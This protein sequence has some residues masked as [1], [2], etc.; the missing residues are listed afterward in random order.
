MAETEVDDEMAFEEAFQA[1]VV[2]FHL[3]LGDGDGARLLTH[4]GTLRAMAEGGEPAA[5][6]G[7]R[8]RCT[9]RCTRRA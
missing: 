2:D 3:A 9:A 1:E 7:G 6:A 4:L 8:R 5:A